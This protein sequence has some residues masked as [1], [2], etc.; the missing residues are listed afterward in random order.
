MTPRYR[1]IGLT[2][3]NG[4]GKGEAAACFAARGYAYLSLSDVIRDELRRDG[5]PETPRH[6]DRQGQRPAP[7]LRA[8]RPGPPGPGPGRPGRRSSTASAIPREVAV[9]R[10]QD[11]LR[12]PGLRRPGRRPLRAGRAGAAG[13]NR[14]PTSR[15]SS[16]RRPRSAARTRPPSSSTPAWPWPTV[17]I[18]NDGT[19]EDLHR[20]PGGGRYD[21]RRASS[22]DEYY[23]G[24]AREVARRSTCFRRSIGAH[25]RPRRPD[26]LDRLRRRAAQDPGQPR[27]R[28]LP[29]GQAGHPPR[30][31]LR[32]LPVASTPSR[33]PSSTPPGPASACSAATCTSSAAR[34]GAAAPINAFPCF[35]CKKMIINAGLDRVVCSTADGRSHGLP[36]RRLGPGLARGRH[37]R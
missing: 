37:P 25:H 10:R 18:V 7:G 2:G 36:D 6:P 1:L 15:P 17:S 21:A 11:G 24:I 26:H 28:L 32:A 4:A 13:T 35:I 22:K 12:P 29:A 34:R 30:P 14:P 16:A 8:R 19:I 31:A 27:A 5:V 33:T 3:T 20:T 23:L 9:L